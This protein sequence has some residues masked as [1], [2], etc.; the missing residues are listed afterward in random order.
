VV[1]TGLGGVGKSTVAGRAMQRLREEG[2]RVP[3][4]KGRFDLAALTLAVG[5]ELLQM[6][7]PSAQKRGA[8]LIHRG[9]DD[10]FGLQLLAQVLAEEPVVLVL[11]D[12]EQ[13]LAP[14]GG[15]FLDPGVGEALAFLVQNARTGR[16][17][18]TS[19]YPIPGMEGELARIR[20]GPL[21][22]AETR[23]LLLRLPA[24]QDVSGAELGRVLRVLGGHPRM[25]A[26]GLARFDLPA[27]RRRCVRAG[28]YRWWRNQHESQSLE[29]A[30]EAVRN[31][32][33]GEAFEEAAGIAQA[34]FAALSRAQQ[35]LG[36]AALAV[37]VLETLPEEHGS[38]AV[39]ADQEAKAYLAL[40]NLARAL[41][42]TNRLLEHHTRLAEAEPD[43]ADYQRDLVISLAR[44]GELTGGP[45]GVARLQRAL[46]IVEDLK[47]GGRLNPADEG[48]GEWLR[49]LLD[50]I[51]P[52]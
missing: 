33:E 22:S 43:R 37:E 44:V 45:E 8:L 17:L 9:L 41:E 1:L 38:F 40:G 10:R 16:L 50:E 11:D 35:T 51:S 6:D 13:N 12:F 7:R 30:I 28:R 32:L 3:A 18:I 21:S 27:H 47:E 23:K 52:G 15:A 19:R 14:G 20:I 2:R 31:F 4:H 26:E 5:T 36:I 48:M 34:C 24:L 49:G 39:V 46:T 42:R 29:D 25:P